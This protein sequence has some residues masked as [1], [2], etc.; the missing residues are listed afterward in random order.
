MTI[1]AHS[2]F[3]DR[4]RRI[5]AGGLNT[6]RTLFVGKDQQIPLPKGRLTKRKRKDRP[7]LNLM[8]LIYGMVM[9]GGSFIAMWLILPP[10]RFSALLF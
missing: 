5:E 9:L 6:N 1:D 10:D 8:P 4:I 3:K 2:D 7:D